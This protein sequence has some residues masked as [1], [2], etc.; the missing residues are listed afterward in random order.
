MIVREIEVR[1]GKNITEVDGRKIT[2]AQAAATIL[3]G[4]TADRP[5]E[6]FSAILLNAQNKALGIVEV[7]VGTLNCS[8]VHPREVFR[9]AILQNAAAIILGHN[10]PSGECAPSRE[11]DDATRRRATVAMGVLASP[12]RAPQRSPPGSR[13]DSA[14]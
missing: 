7:S 1:Y 5:Q 6:I 3:R 4:I 9:A 11:D 14:R 12:E 13:P 2:T 8:L 10:H